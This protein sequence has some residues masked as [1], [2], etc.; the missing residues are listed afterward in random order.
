MS[1]EGDGFIL[2]DDINNDNI[3]S[4][5][6]HAKVE[7]LIPNSMRGRLMKLSQKKNKNKNKSKETPPIKR[8]ADSDD[9]DDNEASGHDSDDDDVRPVRAPEKEK[10][11]RSRK[12]KSSVSDSMIM[13]EAEDASTD[14]LRKE[15]EYERKAIMKNKSLS[16]DE[17]K[18]LIAA[19]KEELAKAEHREASIKREKSRLV[20]E[21][22]DV[23]D[24]DNEDDVDEA[25]YDSEDEKFDRDAEEA[26][27]DESL[28]RRRSKDHKRIQ[29]SRVEEDNY[30]DE[31]CIGGG[32]VR[33]I[34]A[35]GSSNVALLEAAASAAGD[36]RKKATSLL[37]EIKD[38]EE[39]GVLETSIRMLIKVHYSR[40]EVDA[41]DEDAAA[42]EAFQRIESASSMMDDLC[43]EWEKI[44][45]AKT[46]AAFPESM[47]EWAK[48]MSPYV[49]F[50]RNIIPVYY[51]KRGVVPAI[52]DRIE[53]IARS[54]PQPRTATRVG[55]VLGGS[56]QYRP[57]QLVWSMMDRD[58]AEH[59]VASPLMMDCFFGLAFL[60]MMPDSIERIIDLIVE[61][62]EKRNPK[63]RLVMHD[64]EHREGAVKTI[65]CAVDEAL[66]IQTLYEVLKEIKEKLI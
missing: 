62:S 31:R 22:Y 28:L 47:F 64:I 44:S 38:A 51:P 49:H 7:T 52:E 24:S 15:F 41:D 14:L 54:F 30:E 18:Q 13:R 9:D 21:G 5:K 45:M 8:V 37:D 46:R 27:A 43:K 2:D 53:I 35:P 42:V 11:K 58:C 32:L 48:L 33:L 40:L 50:W 6:E 16:Y 17:Q 65:S 39:R 19:A 12:K 20:A 36:M 57:G 23:L 4:N 55:R 63:P 26:D 61:E 56:T 25:M 29:K 34:H 59:I 3:S 10:K 60:Y 66:R 1:D